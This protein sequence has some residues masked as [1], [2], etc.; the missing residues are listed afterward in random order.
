MDALMGKPEDVIV[1]KKQFLE[2][3]VHSLLNQIDAITLHTIIATGTDEFMR[4]AKL[5]WSG[6][7][8]TS[9]DYR[10]AFR[11]LKERAAQVPGGQIDAH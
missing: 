5:E 9:D 6:H 1:D 7:G 3:A 8:F 10:E 2:M 11:R 4:I